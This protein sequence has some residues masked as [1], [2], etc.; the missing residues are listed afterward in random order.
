M[1]LIIYK[2]VN[3][4]N[5]F[6]I[7]THLLRSRINENLL[8]V[9]DE[10]GKVKSLLSLAINSSKAIQNN[11]YASYND[12]INDI[13]LYSRRTDRKDLLRAC[14]TLGTSRN[15]EAQENLISV[16][17]IRLGKIREKDYKYIANLISVKDP[18]IV[19]KVNKYLCFNLE[20][21]HE[22]HRKFYAEYYGF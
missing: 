19:E 2:E 18:H 21:Y 20:G 9:K 15:T 14:I 16:L 22:L 1:H 7:P 13:N 17:R 10:N 3:M 11:D 5:D 6:T 12:A 4:Y 8:P